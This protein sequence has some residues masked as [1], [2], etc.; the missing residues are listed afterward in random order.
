[1]IPGLKKGQFKASK[2]NPDS[3]I[4]MEDTA[5][6]VSKK[7]K[8]AYGPVGAEDID[9]NPLLPFAKY[10]VFSYFKEFKIERPEEYGGCK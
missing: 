7:I 8:G 1:M 4:F 10:F 6:E 9:N 5:K 2:S 3:A